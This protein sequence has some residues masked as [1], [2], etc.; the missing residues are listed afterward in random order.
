MQERSEIGGYQLIQKIG[1]GGMS[2]VYEALDG[3][4]DRVALK[5]LHPSIAA[6]PNSRDR[7]RREVRTLR[8]VTGPYVAQVMDAE[9][10]DEE[11]FLVTEL[12][13]GP[14]LSVDVSENGVFVGK[15]LAD[16]ATE[17]AEALQAIHSKGVL[18]RDLKPSNVMMSQR[19][20]VLIDFGI[21]QIAEESRL[22]MTGMLAHTPG[23]AAPEVLNGEDPTTGAD[24][25]S[26][27]A[28]LAYAATGHAPF[29]TGQSPKVTRKVH[30]GEC[31]LTG[32]DP[33]VAYALEAALNPRPDRRPAPADVIGMLNGTI[34]VSEEDLALGPAY[35]GTFPR[36]QYME[37]QS[38]HIA[39]ATEHVD[40]YQNQPP[41]YAPQARHA[42]QYP[43][44][45]QRHGYPVSTPVEQTQS[46][47]QQAHQVEQ[48]SDV[49]QAPPPSIPPQGM[50]QPS[51]YD[52]SG[53]AVFHPRQDSAVVAHAR[54]DP[55][56]S[57]NPNPI[58]DWLK[59]APR[60][61]WLTLML[62]IVYT[63]WAGVLPIIMIG[64]FFVYMLIS[65]IVGVS[66]QALIRSRLERGGRFRAESMTVLG[67]LPISILAGGTRTLAS[68]GSGIVLGGALAW[69]G[70]AAFGLDEIVCVA[71]GALI[72]T[73]LAWAY[74]TSAPSRETTR[75]LLASIA[76]SAGYRLFWLVL[77]VALLSLALPI[78]TNGGGPDWVPSSTPFIFN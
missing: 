74:P 17:L 12:I 58:P 13:D 35:T 50:S 33:V 42:V 37:S 66:R 23:Y 8:Q 6:D 25:W 26:W 48:R 24:W 40:G 45:D 29:G 31:D 52:H 70:F 41:Y 38:P 60:R 65:S 18:H 9:T 3:G 46:Q 44:H 71:S 4:G 43:P 54:F 64:L 30:T 56:F 11:A 72:G 19:G 73:W 27:A 15:D 57:R 78:Y 34:A 7:L 51:P 53:S 5:L 59:P 32:A 47:S 61:P 77:G 2:T 28:T 49:Q 63:A 21:A 62:W 68:V 75:Y 76:P 10:E 20:P 67:R 14:T 69:L 16:L 22:T 39:E 55:R 1:F 36:A